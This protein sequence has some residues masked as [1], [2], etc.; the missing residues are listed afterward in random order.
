MD[1]YSLLKEHL[2][3]AREYKSSEAGRGAN[4]HKLQNKKSFKVAKPVSFLMLPKTLVQ[5]FHDHGRNGNGPHG[6]G[7]SSED[8]EVSVTDCSVENIQSSDFKPH[9][10]NINAVKT[11]KESVSITDV[12]SKGI[13]QL[14]RD[15]QV[16]AAL[17]S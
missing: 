10:R 5:S 11:S 14:G 12:K 13:N 3:L 16:V 8:C 15:S 4:R 1:R 9:L 7:D 2:L 17:T 6:S